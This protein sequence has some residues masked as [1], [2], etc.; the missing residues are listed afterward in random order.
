MSIIFR[1]RWR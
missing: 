1:K